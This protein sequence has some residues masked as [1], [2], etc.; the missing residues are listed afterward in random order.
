MMKERFVRL[1]YRFYRFGHGSKKPLLC[2]GT[3]TLFL[4]LFFFINRNFGSLIYKV[5]CLFFLGIPFYKMHLRPC[6]RIATIITNN[7]IILHLYLYF[8][9]TYKVLYKH[10]YIVVVPLKKKK[11]V[12]CFQGG[13][14][15]PPISPRQSQFPPLPSLSRSLCV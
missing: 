7:H 15:A 13:T 12:F 6:K 10:L 9:Y 4:I 14:G 2:L 5:L 3:L 1:L 8:I 11:V